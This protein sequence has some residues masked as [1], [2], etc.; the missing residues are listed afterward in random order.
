MTRYYLD[1]DEDFATQLKEVGEDAI[2]EA[3]RTLAEEEAPPADEIDHE[4]LSTAEKKR[5]RIRRIRRNGTSF[6]DKPVFDDE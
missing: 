1:I 6:D 4:E 2:M 5:R 3:L